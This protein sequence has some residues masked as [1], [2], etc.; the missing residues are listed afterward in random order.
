MEGIFDS[1][2]QLVGWRHHRAVLDRDGTQCAYLVGGVLYSYFG[3]FVGHYEDG[4]YRDGAGRPVARHVGA[5][6][7][8]LL[9]RVDQTQVEPIPRIRR[10][11]ERL[12]NPPPPPRLRSLRWS[13]I[14]WTAYINGPRRLS[15]RR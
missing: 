13:P 11:P 8:P 15:R 10:G 14:G 2:G 7:G 5:S 9:P 3:E 4:F 12:E 1:S 6:G